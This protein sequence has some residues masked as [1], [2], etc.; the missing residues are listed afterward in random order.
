MRGS[1]CVLVC[2]FMGL[3]GAFTYMRVAAWLPQFSCAK[4]GE[5]M[6]GKSADTLTD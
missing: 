4:T 3:C 6:R 1:R 5:A 2:V